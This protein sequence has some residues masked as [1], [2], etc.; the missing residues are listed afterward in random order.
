MKTG[1]YTIEFRQMGDAAHMSDAACV[2]KRRTDVVDQL[3]FDQLLAIPDGIEHFAG[4]DGRDR[5]LANEL[6]AALI[7]SGRWIFE[8]EQAIGLEISRQARG[9]DRR[10]TMMHVMKQLEVRA[11]ICAQSFKEFWRRLEITRC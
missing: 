7:F 9:L 3:F 4:G 10:Q 11:V 6:E 2:N 1:A 8:P 5:M